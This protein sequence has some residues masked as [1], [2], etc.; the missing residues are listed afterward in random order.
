MSSLPPA[1]LHQVSLHSEW[2][3]LAK[4]WPRPPARLGFSQMEWLPASVPGHVHQ[5]LLHLG[6]LSDPFARLGEL[7]SQWV[8][9]EDWI[10]RIRFHVSAA[11]ERPRRILRFE[12]LD[13]ICQVFVDAV[14]RARHDNMFVP[15]EL[16][17]SDLEEGWHELHV[18][19]HSAKRVGQERRDAYFRREGL[20]PTIRWFDERAFVRKAQY[21]FGWDWGPRLISA[22]IWRPVFLIE[23]SA[24]LLDVHV[25]S[26]QKANGSFELQFE[27]VVEGPAR[28]VHFLFG[29]NGEPQSPP[30]E[31]GSLWTVNDPQL[32]WPAGLGPQALSTVVSF[33][34]PRDAH[35]RSFE[36]AQALALH[37]RRTRIG[38]RHIELLQK[39]DEVGESFEFLVN[40][41][42][43]WAVGANWIPDHSFPSQITKDQYRVQLQRAVAMNMNMLRVWGGGLYET[44]AFYDLADELGLLIWQDFPYS[45]SHYPD[46]PPAQAVATREAEEN[47]R[48]LRN[49]PSLTLWCGNNENQEMFEKRWEGRDVHPARLHGEQIYEATL[50]SLLAR[51]DPG[52]P[53]VRSSPDRGELP[54]DGRFGDEHYWD[55]WH[56]RGDWKHYEDSMGRFA[57]EFGFASAPGPR[58]WQRI[59]HDALA[60]PPR[61]LS[62]RWHD[63]TLKGYETFLGYTELHYPGAT[64]IEE[65]SYYSQLNQRDA[66]RFGIEHFRRSEFC[67]GTLIWQ[68]NDCWPAQS[69]AV[70]DFAGENKAA[71]FELRRLYAPAL[72]SL[73]LDQHHA[74][75]WVIADNTQQKFVGRLQLQATS[76]LDGSVLAEWNDDILLRAGDRAL[77]LSVDLSGLPQTTT[78]L[79]ARLVDSAPL[80][81]SD[82]ARLTDGNRLADG[83]PLADS[84]THRL[85]EEPKHCQVA[86]PRLLIRRVGDELDVHADAPAIDL[87]LWDPAGN[88]RLAKNFIT[89]SRPGSVCIP[90]QGEF[91]TLSARCL[92]GRC[93]VSYS[94]SPLR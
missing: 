92:G 3:F 20:P 56:G 39:A 75:V 35:P 82:G 76:T 5:D 87:Y 37:E 57:S 54:S 94:E 78:L 1:R 89:L 47:V 84:A 9:E 80:A 85:L 59:Q 83:T 22:G 51:L 81:D 14:P 62:A 50:P 11:P 21:M 31:E 74:Q 53:Y 79:T 10:Y 67:R 17:V 64:T 16:D 4:S 70:I 28:V 65:W 36:E 48:R 25:S 52:R 8:D 27:S 58:T 24:R 60:L 7:G 93:A 41:R 90:Y 61:H 49:H 68:L 46:D 69:W 26:H 71:A 43:L 29:S 2:E 40:G 19:F 6:I 42:P 86:C 91:E 72:V 32:W 73:R 88:T 34:I 63:K 30:L 12:G 66:L 55:V 33:A 38:L 23:Y 77:S 13:T 45:C 15:L 18:E 44:D